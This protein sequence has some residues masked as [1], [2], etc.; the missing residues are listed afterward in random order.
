MSKKVEIDQTTLSVVDK[1]DSAFS[2]FVWYIRTFSTM[3]IFSSGVC[4]VIGLVIFFSLDDIG[5]LAF[6]D[7]MNFVLLSYMNLGGL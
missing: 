6:I 7:C 2:L 5:K 1:I 4:T 3:L